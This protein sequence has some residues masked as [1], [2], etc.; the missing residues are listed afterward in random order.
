MARTD[1]SIKRTGGYLIGDSPVDGKDQL[2]SPCF[3][4]PHPEHNAV[5]R[6]IMN[7]ATAYARQNGYTNIRCEVI[8]YAARTIPQGI[9]GWKEISR[10]VIPFNEKV[11][12]IFIV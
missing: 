7:E 11:K 10:R 6:R 2:I 1:R 8:T 4:F 12:N 3:L 5:N 9:I